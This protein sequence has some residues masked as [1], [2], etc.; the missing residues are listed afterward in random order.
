MGAKGAMAV[1]LLSALGGG[2]TA[3]GA[4]RD[5]QSHYVTVQGT[6]FALG[7][8]PFYFVGAN[9]GVMHGPTQRRL[10]ARTLRE[11][12]SDGLT[13]VRIW[14]LGEGPADATDWQRSWQL[15]R[16]GPRGWIPAAGRHLDQVL[17]TSRALGLKVILVLGNNW[18]DYGGIPQ[19]L[20]WARLGSARFGARDVF[21]GRSRVRQWYR[22]HVDR[23]VNR[24]SSI[25]GV[26]YGDDPTIMAWELFNESTATTSGF[27]ARR[28]F[29][30][31]TAKRL[32]ARAPRQLIAA[33]VTGYGT[34]ARRA[35]WLRLCR[36]KEFSYCDAHLYPEES[37]RLQRPR[38][39]G[40]LIDDRVQLAHH[41]AG[42]PVLFGEFGFTAGISRHKGLGRT[43]PWWVDRFLRRV[44]YDGAA[45]AL[46]WLYLPHCPEK[47]RFP[48]WVDHPSS[49]PLR[50]TI[51][52]WAGRFRTGPPRRINPRLGKRHGARPLYPTQ[53]T[54]RRTPPPG[55]WVP[56]KATGPLAQ[57]RR[58]LALPI[59][60]FRRA[61][62]YDMGE[63]TRGAVAHVYGA[64]S[65]F[66]EYPIP[67]LKA[68][69]TSL[70]IRLRLSS[71]Y[72]G[73][74]APPTGVSQVV[75]RLGGRVVKR[76]L[77]A[78]DDGLGT[79]VHIRV[80]DRAALS[81]LRRT[82][83]LRLEVPPGPRA[84]G[85]CVYGD[86]GLRGTQDRKKIRGRTG[87]ITLEAI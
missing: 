43:Q 36:L 56:M 26:R 63:Y 41:V 37:W 30:R 8:R 16:A 73:A 77:A 4:P 48:I 65:G 74:S 75:V 14:A 10:A 82:T 62:F 60:G 83:T 47:R 5:D 58:R 39:L 32:R 11:A 67:P 3:R 72:P 51:R 85:L 45:G 19:Y 76:L 38:D 35:E 27:A 15:F 59:T 71:E 34:P 64:G 86:K 31:E 61:R 12:R 23:L 18:G 22:R 66:W 42:K 78:P 17:A 44:H 81:H 50:Q 53:F 55:R 25:T 69:V 46:V 68:A 28:R 2:P 54:V 49:R 24:R 7:G 1:L 70:D 6:R 84:R 87:P 79:V 80:E 52:R 40:P 9:V 13:V 33:G 57:P 29:L 20:R 21:F